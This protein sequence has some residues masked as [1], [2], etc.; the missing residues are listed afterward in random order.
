M[1]DN[2]PSLKQVV[3]KEQVISALIEIRGE[4]HLEQL[5]EFARSLQE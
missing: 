1:P 2:G 4:L 3:R 5:R